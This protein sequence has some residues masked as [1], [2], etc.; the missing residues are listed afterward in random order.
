MY[1]QREDDANFAKAQCLVGKPESEVMRRLGA[2]D[3]VWLAYSIVD[4]GYI[5]EIKFAESLAQ[6]DILAQLSADGHSVCS[7]GFSKREQKWYGWS[8]RA[9][10]G[11][12]IGHV[13][14][15][16]DAGT[17]NGISVGFECQTL[18]DCKL[19]ALAFADAVS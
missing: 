9:A 18:D 1:R 3:G 7:I 6:R 2:V 17:G 16:G 14:G 5:G 11:F 19:C 4:G 15:D 13:V 8:H 12:E 10:F